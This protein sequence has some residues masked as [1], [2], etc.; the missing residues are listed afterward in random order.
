MV[1]A[2]LHVNPSTTHPEFNV[3]IPKLVQVP[4]FSV[5]ILVVFTINLPGLIVPNASI[6]TLV[7][8]QV[9]PVWSIII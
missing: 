4:P 8:L 7:K 5:T 2:P 1:S 9:L 3:V 6:L